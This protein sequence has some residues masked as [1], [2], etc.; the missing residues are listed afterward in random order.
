[1]PKPTTDSIR[2][3]VDEQDFPHEQLKKRIEDDY[4]TWRLEPFILGADYD[5]YTTNEPRNLA[6]KAIDILATA[7]IQARIPLQNNDEQERTRIS[8]TE[9]FYYGALALANY[10]LQN[11]LQPSVQDQLA[12]HAVLRGWI[13]IRALFRKNDKGET[14]PDIAI[15][16]ILHTRWD[17]G[18]DGFLWICHKRP[19]TKAQAK[20][21]YDM[22]IAGA[23]TYNQNDR[24]YDYWDD[25]W[26]AVVLNN[27]FA[28]EPW[29]HKLGHIPVLLKTVGSVPLVQST[30]HT[31]TIKDSGESIFSNDRNIYPHKNKLVTLYSTV[32]GQAAH[33]P[34]AITSSG[35]K[36][37]FKKS[38]YY[39][40]S[41]IQLDSDKNET[42]EALY[43]P[44]MPRQTGEL[45]SIVQRD[46]ST[47]GVAPIA[48]GE[49][50]FQLPYSGIKELLDAA[51][52]IIKPRQKAI[53]ESLTWVFRE[54][55]GQYGKGKFG[56]L[57]IHGRDGANEYFDMEMSAKDMKG[58]WFPEVKLLADLPENETEKHAM[59]KLSIDTGMLS[60][61]SASDRYIGVQDT[62]SEQ[63]KIN[64]HR[65]KQLPSVQVREY[66]MALIE[67]GRPDLANG[68]MKDYYMSLGMQ[69][70]GAEGEQGNP[71]VEEQFASGLPNT[72]VAPEQLG[73]RQ[74][75]PG[76]REQF[77]GDEIAPI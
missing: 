71:P 75:P 29:E 18:S 54:L 52:S 48:S 41:V 8:A 40:G 17:I 15:W 5:N 57:R 10:R 65:A 45:L 27:K 76:E 63:R 50:A 38:P 3:K 9:R 73:K 56:K 11:T 34:L 39:K 60:P 46:L 68:V 23:S 43:K 35:G 16:D 12:F 59:A 62:D 55:A 69:P 22:D 70:P 61:Q 67:D 13:A 28:I 14:V 21:E 4:D 53:E 36:R 64:V 58:D 47:G 31:D 1:M 49:L 37:D 32:L 66:A 42:V 24:V 19:I 74:R 72:M 77:R 2:K 51:K 6:N 44:E 25:E 7:P 33:N 20:A 26:N 30:R